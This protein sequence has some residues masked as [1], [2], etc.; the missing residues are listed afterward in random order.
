VL[1]VLV[2][3]PILVAQRMMRA[4]KAQQ[5]ASE[6][7]DAELKARLE[8]AEALF[9]KRCATAGEFIDKTVPDVKGVVWM[10][11]RPKGFNFG[12]QFKLDDP[13]GQDCAEEDC[14]K[15]LLRATFIIPNHD[16]NTPSLPSNGYE[17]VETTDPRDGNKYRYT[18]GVKAL[19]KRTSEDRSIA[20]K[21]NN[22]VDP[23]EDIF[24]FGLNREPIVSYS[25][26]YGIT[27]D[28]IS[29]HDDRENWIAGSAVSIVD[30]GTDKIIAK[31][32]GYM[33]DPG[34]GSTAGFR[35]PWSVARS[36]K[37]SVSGAIAQN[38][39]AAQQAS[40]FTFKVIKPIQGEVK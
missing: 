32:V 29:T 28:D 30:I 1:V 9:K 10:K 18:A 38:Q 8:V 23:G 19:K 22:G 2:L 17:Y 15:G 36:N 14:I 6:K 12:D 26:K 31:Q 21:N 40:E 11:W 34:L 27:W 33:M 7:M 16:M 35:T 39:G 24:G 20:T 13:Y 5:L 4:E 3:L 25:A 37:C